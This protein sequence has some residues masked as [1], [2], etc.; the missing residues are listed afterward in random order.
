M[1][2]LYAGKL[3]QKLNKHMGPIFALKWNKKGDSLLSGSVDKTAVV[4]DA[5]S[6]EP[7]QTFE[8]HT[9]GPACSCIRALVKA[10]K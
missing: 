2:R 6:G 10:H 5:K 9:G 8:F 7:R 3:K 4:W 1:L